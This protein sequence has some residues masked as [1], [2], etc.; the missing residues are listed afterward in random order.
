MIKL[1]V[2]KMYDT[3]NVPDHI[4]EEMKEVSLKM[5]KALTPLFQEHD[6]NI[7]MAAINWAHAILIKELVIDD[8]EEL[9][10]AAKTSA[11]CLVNN[12]EFLGTIKSDEKD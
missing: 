6:A 3:N 9:M 10:N 12:V 1:K 7:A 2:L 5:I 4:L 11:I 8:A